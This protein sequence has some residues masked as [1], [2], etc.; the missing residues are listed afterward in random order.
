MIER[1]FRPTIRVA[2][3]GVLLLGCT[4]PPASGP[5]AADGDG[6]TLLAPVVQGDGFIDTGSF[7]TE[8]EGAGSILPFE[9]EVEDEVA[10]ESFFAVRSI[11]PFSEDSAGPKFVKWGDLDNDGLPDLVTVWNQSQVVQIQLQRRDA[12]GD[13]TFE[14]VQIDGNSPLA[15][16]AGAEL[17]DMDR[18]GRLDIVLLVKDNASLAICPANGQ[19]QDE[20]FVGELVIL[21]SPAVGA[22]TIG[23]NWQQVRLPA[24]TFGADMESDVDFLQNLRS[25]QNPDPCTQNSDCPTGDSCV[26]QLCR[27]TCVTTGDCIPGMDCISG[28]CVPTGGVCLRDSDCASDE[29]CQDNQCVFDVLVVL[30][31]NFPGVVFG[32][33]RAIDIPENGGMNA[34]AVGDVTGDGFPDIVMTSNVPEPPCH[35]GINEVELFPNPGPALSRI[36]TEWRQIILD[37][38]GGLLK[39]IVLSDVDVDGDL[40]VIVTRLA[41]SQNVHWLTNPVRD[42]VASR[43][44]PVD[45][46]FW[47]WQRRA[48]GQIDGGADIMTVG[49]VDGDG[50]DDI[51]VRSNGGRVV[52]WFRHPSPTDDLNVTDVLTGIPWSVYTLFELIDRVPLGL[53]VGD[54]NFDGQPEVLLAADGS[55]FWLD[56]STAETVLDEWSSNL[57][58]DDAQLDTTLFAS[59]GPALINELLVIDIDC[60]GTNDVIATMDRQSLSGLSTDVVVWFRNILLPED[61]GLDIPLVPACPE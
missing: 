35:N 39:D 1:V 48:V 30:N 43:P 33:G 14:S 17:A 26:D 20:A 37:G 45:T 21:F 60:D 19:V 47:F 57:I 11:D 49:D 44:V 7:F 8:G 58:I 56:S 61:V 22:I 52:Q 24:S 4:D 9:P 18:D 16:M 51:L 53:A 15:I 32:E 38:G 54:I 5:P 3:C 36:G 46:S 42:P 28:F 41:I 12:V 23:G 13:V 10:T 2:F 29:V 59:Q 50:L 34:L 55:V 40:D 6:E 31:D 25:A 27:S